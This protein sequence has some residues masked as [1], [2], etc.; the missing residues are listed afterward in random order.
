MG[1]RHEPRTRGDSNGRPRREQRRRKRLAE[2][3]RRSGN[4]RQLHVL[5]VRGADVVDE[6][7]ALQRRW[8]IAGGRED[9]PVR[10]LPHRGLAHITDEQLPRPRAH[11][12]QHHAP[13]AAIA[14]G[15][16]DV[17]VAGDI[18]PEI[19]VGDAHTRRAADLYRCDVTGIGHD[20]QL[21]A[22][23]RAGVTAR[24]G[25]AFHVQDAADHRHA[26]SARTSTRDPRSAW[27]TCNVVASG[28]S[29][30]RRARSRR[31]AGVGE[32]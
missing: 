32:S 31:A 10:R 12:R 28:A 16:R 19:G 4:E 27:S 29:D 13:L 21:V 11:G 2:R 22:L 9:Q 14:V 1:L 20:R 17:Q 7:P 15:A 24:A 23:C 5:P 30:T 8:A 6:R 26:A 3:L 25:A 18:L